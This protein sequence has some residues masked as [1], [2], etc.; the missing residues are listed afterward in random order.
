MTTAH[1]LEPSSR[2]PL[3][4]WPG[5]GAIVLGWLAL[6]IIPVVAPAASFYG[7]SAARSPDW[8]SS[9][10]GCSSAALP[11]PSAWWASR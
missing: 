6:L 11:G 1:I 7:S 5:V 9:C 3:R 10:G 4:L 2:R 8:W